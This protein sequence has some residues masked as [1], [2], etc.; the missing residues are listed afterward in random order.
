MKKICVVLL[1]CLALLVGCAPGHYKIMLRDG[2]QLDTASKPALDTKT[3]YYTY[4]DENGKKV[5]LKE[6]D[7]LTI[8]EK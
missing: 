5:L 6:A 4:V 2:R 1:L 3:G 8:T 7:V